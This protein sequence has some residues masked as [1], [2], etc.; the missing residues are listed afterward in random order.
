VK[1]PGTPR[2]VIS[3]TSFCAITHHSLIVMGSSCSLYGPV[4]VLE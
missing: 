1:T 3:M 4:P 2:F